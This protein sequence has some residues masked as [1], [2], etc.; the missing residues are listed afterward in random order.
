[1]KQSIFSKPVLVLFFSFLCI[2]SHAQS[3][4]KAMEQMIDQQFKLAASQYK[5]LEKNVPDSMMPKT[6]NKNTGKVESSNTKWWCSGFFPGSL[7]YIYEHTNDQDVLKIAQKRLAIQEKEKHYTGNHDLGFM[8]YCSFGNA[9]RLFKKPGDKATIDTAAASLTTRYRPQ[10]KSIQSWNK[11]QNFNCPVIIDNM[12]NLELLLWVSQNGGD[13]RFREVAINHANS[14]LANHYRPDHS[15]FHVL[16]YTLETGKF[17]GKNHQGFNDASAWARGQAWG[18][19]GFTMMYRFVKDEKYLQQAR[20]IAQFLLNHPNMPTDKI[21]Y[22]DF[23]A[24][25]IPNALRDASAASIIASG[26]LELSRYTKGKESSNYVDAARQIIVKLASEEYLA[27]P[28]ENGGFLLKHGVGF[29]NANSEVDQPLTY[30]DYYF[31]EA[32]H[33]YKEWILK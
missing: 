11:N 22:W 21:P 6:L 1:M 16:D 8:M 27:K 2:L 7:L 26:L 18:F 32:M 5:I 10:I 24:P 19:Y 4:K 14:T 29:F 13:Q 23:N 17:I 25:T 9:Y 30:G 28:G 3:S 31:L 15:A 20:D 12:M 33:R